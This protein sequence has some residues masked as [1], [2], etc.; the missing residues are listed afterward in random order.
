MKNSDRRKYFGTDGIRGVY[1]EDLTDGLAMLAGNSL[2]MSA[3]GGT[4]VVGRDTRASGANLSRA[5]AEGVLSA[6]A[7]VVGLG[8]VNTPCVA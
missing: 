3:D 8:V 6:A 7:N 2:G 1:G 4:V 5:L